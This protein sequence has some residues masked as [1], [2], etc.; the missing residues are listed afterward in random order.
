MRSRGGLSTRRPRAPRPAWDNHLRRQ[1]PARSANEAHGPAAPR[2]LRTRP[3]LP[4]LLRP[5]T[6]DPAGPRGALRRPD[7]TAATHDPRP[8]RAPGMRTVTVEPRAA[9]AGTSPCASLRFRLPSGPFLSRVC[10]AHCAARSWPRSPPRSVLLSGKGAAWQFQ[11]RRA[12]PLHGLVSEGHRC[13]RHNQWL[14]GQC[15]GSLTTR[16]RSCSLGA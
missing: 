1:P 9:A 3:R 11:R 13:L 10:S 2:R 6:P 16:M 15:W 8:P 4:P 14:R 12:L 7:W 5:G